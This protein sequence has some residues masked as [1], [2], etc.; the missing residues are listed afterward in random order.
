LFILAIA[1]SVA[2]IIALLI[3]PDTWTK[4]PM[5][6]ENSFQNQYVMTINSGKFGINN[7][8]V[9]P[10]P[11]PSGEYLVFLGIVLD[12]RSG[13]AFY[14]KDGGYSALANGRDATRALLTSSL[15]AEDMTE[16]IDDVIEKHKNQMHQWLV[17][18]L[19]KYPQIGVVEGKYWNGKGQ[20]TAMMEAI[21]AKL[22]QLSHKVSSKTY[23]MDACTR[24]NET[25]SCKDPVLVP[26]IR[27]S[28]GKSSCVCVN[29]NEIYAVETTD[30]V[31]VHFSDCE[32]KGKVCHRKPFEI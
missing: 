22:G 17:F 10:L 23:K 27:R 12:V 21:V 7:S 13:A 26:K 9:L 3:Y 14:G 2:M 29:E 1:P 25:V 19:N 20:P 31:I 32:N 28:R 4:C 16:D 11:V 15:K 18:F 6:V 5:F 24:N 8:H 30:F